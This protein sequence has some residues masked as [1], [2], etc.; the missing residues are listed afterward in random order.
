VLRGYYEDIFF[1]GYLFLS[2][3]GAGVHARVG[4]IV[5]KRTGMVDVFSFSSLH[6]FG[7]KGSFQSFFPLSSFIHLP[8]YTLGAWVGDGLALLSGMGLAWSSVAVGV[9]CCVFKR[10]E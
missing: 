2:L 4:G 7:S 10:L 5:T 1:L 9:S 8:I 3:S 6:G